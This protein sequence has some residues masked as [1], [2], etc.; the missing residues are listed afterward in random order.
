MISNLIKN[1]FSRIPIL[2]KERKEKRK[3]RKTQID[4]I[5]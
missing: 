1:A 5:I 2:K 3:R 4:S